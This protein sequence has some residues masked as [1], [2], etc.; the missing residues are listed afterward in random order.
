MT[1][2]EHWQVAS[3]ASGK[4]SKTTEPHEREIILNFLKNLFGPPRLKCRPYQ[5]DFEIVVIDTGTKQET[6]QDIE[7]GSGDF[8]N[9]SSRAVTRTF[10]DPTVTMYCV[11][12]GEVR[13]VTPTRR[14]PN[15]N[16]DELIASQLNQ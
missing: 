6:T 5:H 9:K 2:Q 7:A 4:T 3:L 15:M 10:I 8:D 14:K 13:D 11:R 12:C 1:K 16:A